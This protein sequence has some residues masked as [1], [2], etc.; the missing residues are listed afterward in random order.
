M[1]S[2]LFHCQAYPDEEFQWRPEDRRATAIGGDVVSVKEVLY[3]RIDLQP[4]AQW[5]GCRRVE[6]K[7]CILD[8]M[9][10]RH[11]IS[12]AHRDVLPLQEGMPSGRRCV[13]QAEVSFIARHTLELLADRD[14][15]DA[16]GGVV[17]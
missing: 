1:G 13:R 3:L 16:V 10:A 4:A 2:S 5:N 11:C 6:N 17:G 12:I 9:V 8:Q 7:M 15:I 14:G